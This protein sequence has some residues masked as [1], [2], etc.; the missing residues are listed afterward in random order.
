MATKAEMRAEIEALAQAKD[1]AVDV[2][3]LD[4][5]NVAQLQA[6]LESLVSEPAVE[7]AVEPELSVD[8]APGSTTELRLD[9]PLTAPPTPTVDG[10]DDKSLGGPPKPG[11]KRYRHPYTVAEG[12]S[13]TTHRRGTKGAFD[14]VRAD[15]FVGGQAQLDELVASGHVVKKP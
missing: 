7:V 14:R 11:S 3:D 10:A 9:S 4:R 6:V 2:D 12:C 8:I 15:D 13:V 1:V 5:M